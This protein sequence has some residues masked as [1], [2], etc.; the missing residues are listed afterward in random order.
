M[1]PAD[2][3]RLRHMLE[4]AQKIVKFTHQRSRADLDSDEKL[5]LAVVRL[6]EI[7]G[8]AAKAVSQTLRASHPHVPWSTIGRTR[9]RLIH[10]YFNVDLDIVWQIAS[11]DIPSLVV[12]LQKIV[13][14]A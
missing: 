1:L 6:L 7:C 8:E 9:D 13:S 11:G 14:E 3:T 2:E 10:G 5:S 12:E 4:A